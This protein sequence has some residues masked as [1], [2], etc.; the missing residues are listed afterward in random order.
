[1]VL[2][3]SLGGLKPVKL[4]KPFNPEPKWIRAEGSRLGGLGFRGFKLV[5]NS[6]V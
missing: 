3:K 4:L 6:K 5:S 2:L 1:M